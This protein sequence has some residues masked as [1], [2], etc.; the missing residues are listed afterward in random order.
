[1]KT[2]KIAALL[3]T[4]AVVSGAL[5]TASAFAM[6]NGYYTRANNSGYFSNMMSGFNTSGHGNMMNGYS[7][8]PNS[9]TDCGNHGQIS[10][11]AIPTGN[12][13]NI[14]QSLTDAKNYLT[15]LNNPD[16][17]IK[18]VEEHEGREGYSR[19]RDCRSEH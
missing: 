13:I 9:A 1:M 2:W 6:M 11:S 3:V 16:L 18:K 12:Q 7:Y 15:A 4:V 5:F 19:R 10:S 14:N 8:S 17:T